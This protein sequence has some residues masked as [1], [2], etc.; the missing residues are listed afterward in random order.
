MCWTR[1]WVT[2]ADPCF[3]TK[4]HA[5]QRLPVRRWE[6]RGETRAIARVGLV[7]SLKSRFSRDPV[8]DRVL[9]ERV[10]S[11]LGTVVKHPRSIDVTAE[12]GRVTL[13][14]PILA[15]EVNRLIDTVQGVRGVVD[16]ENRL[17]MHREPDNVPGLQ[18]NPPRPRRGE[19]FELMQTN[20]SPTTRLLAA[21]AGGAL[22]V[23]GVTR[24]NI[25][26]AGLGLIG[27]ALVGRA[28]TI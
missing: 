1:K 26:A 10:R 23:Y 20:W 6:R 21:G 27:L 16:V 3:A 7:A 4:Y 2:D 18:G 12:N 8:D 17:D 15:H 5:R 14:G 13:S 11:K 28:L 24:Q 19:Q 25:P 9:A 22:V